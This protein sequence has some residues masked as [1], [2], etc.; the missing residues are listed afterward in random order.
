MQP[1]HKIFSLNGGQLSYR[2]CGNGPVLFLLHGLNGNSK[3]WIK[4]FEELA[5]EFRLIAWD[6]PGYGMSSLTEANID[7]YADLAAGLMEGLGIAIYAVLGHSMG[8]VVAGRLS[9]RHARN[10][11][12]LILSCTHPGTGLI[13][14]ED[15]GKSYLSRIENRRTLSDFEFG[16]FGAGRMLPETVSA[17][18][19][20]IVADIASE[21]GSEG[22]EAAIKVINY[23]NNRTVL[24]DLN[25]PVLIIDAELD[26]V[27]PPERTTILEELMPQAGRAT[28]IGAGHAPYLEN[29]RTYNQIISEFMNS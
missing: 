19:F 27:V 18:T 11:N 15:L 6:A 9:G 16:R 20:E 28:V 22:L 2:T 4:Q 10:I 13:A 29:A 1:E 7:I 24:S 14:D 5:D 25:C 26:P 3:S 21:V 23:A 12:R 8:G 17:D